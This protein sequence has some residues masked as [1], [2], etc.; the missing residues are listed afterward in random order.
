MLRLVGERFC[1]GERVGDDVFVFGII[2]ALG[3]TGESAS[4]GSFSL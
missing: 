1:A 2:H 3:P 4:G